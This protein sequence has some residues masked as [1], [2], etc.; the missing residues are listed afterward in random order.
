MAFLE[1][2][3]HGLLVRLETE[4]LDEGTGGAVGTGGLAEEEAGVDD[5]GVVE[6]EHGVRR[7]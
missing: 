2:L 4:N 5:F 1:G 7:Q 3:G 6:K